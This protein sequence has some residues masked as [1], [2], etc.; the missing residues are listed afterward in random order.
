MN[1][2]ETP[3]SL[4]SNV[5]IP[6]HWP[7]QADLLQWC[8]NMSPGIAT[9]LII[10][11][12]IYLLFGYYIFR[13]LVL[14]NATVAGAAIGAVIGQHMQVP[15]PGA[16]IGAMLL[17]A[18]SWIV[19]KYAVALMG[20]FFGV[21]LGASI[22]RACGL[23]PSLA[24]AGALTGLVGFGLLA[25]ILFKESVMMLTSLQGSVML[26]L[27]ILGLVYQYQAA[28]PM[29]TENM[30]AK[31]FLLPMAILIPTVLG[32]VFQQTQAAAEAEAAKKKK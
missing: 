14:L 24:W 17:A 29:V 18:V 8:Q 2:S 10:G 23:Q 21:L 11:G 27:G 28:A 13:G 22:W 5:A 1:P 4:W 6:S 26:I 32:L 12:I 30:Q 20:G 3:T 19:M 7:A 9:V 15:I 31:S 25:F 16:I